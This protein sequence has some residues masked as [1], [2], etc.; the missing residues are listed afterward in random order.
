MRY[1]ILLVLTLCYAT[2]FGQ[3][4]AD[5]LIRDGNY[6]AVLEWIDGQPTTMTVE[7]KQA[8]ARALI[9][10]GRFG[11]A[12]TLINGLFKDASS[13][14]LAYPDLLNLRGFLN[15][16]T[17]RNDAAHEDFMAALK[18]Y[19][20]AHFSVHP[21]VASCHSNLGTLYVNTGKYQQAEDQFLQSLNIR[22][23]LFGTSHPEVAAA[24]NDLGL[25]Y[26]Q[27]DPGK[28][29][30]YYGKARD[31]Y[32]SNY[33][34]DHPKIAITSTNLGI[35]HKGQEDFS[36]AIQNFNEALRIWQRVFPDGHPNQA[37]VLSYL[38]QTYFSLG[39][40]AT[41]HTLFRDA[42]K[43]YRSAYGDRHPDLAATYNQ[44]ATLYIKERS[45]DSALVILQQALIANTKS[46]TSQ[47]LNVN[48]S[49]QDH[50]NPY[51]MVY[52]HQLKAQV[53]ETRY[54]AHTLRLE[55]LRRAVH[56]IA[57]CDT[58]I[59]SIRR[60]SPE[61]T[62]KIRLGSIV[63]EVF[64]DGVR[65]CHAIGELSVHPRSWEERAF[66][67][68]EKSKAAV[69]L[70]SIAEA[71][72]R[73]YAGLPD[74]LLESERNLK[75]RLQ[76]A[77]RRLAE[78][79]GQEEESVVRSELFRLKQEQAQFTEYLSIKYPRYFNLKYQESV[80]DVS[81]L[82]NLIGPEDAVVSYFVAEKNPVL[83]IFTLTKKKF[84]VD[85]RAIRGDLNRLINGFYNSIKLGNH[86]TYT[87]SA[88]AL[89]ALLKP[90]LPARVKDVVVIPSGALSKI[91]LEALPLRK[92]DRSQAFASR[93]W[94][95]RWTIG[96]DFSTALMVGGSES[97]TETNRRILLCAPVQFSPTR[98]LSDLPGTQME[99]DSIAR[100]FPGAQTMLTGAS[101]S[102]EAFRNFDLKQYRYIHL[103]THGLADEAAPELSRIFL[104]ESENADGDLFTGEIYNLNLKAD[105]VTLSA[106]QTGLG[107]VHRGEGMMGLSRALMYAGAEKVVVSYWS[108]SDEATAQLMVN[109]YRNFANTNTMGSSS[110]SAALAEAKRS[111][112]TDEKFKDPFYWAAFVMLG[113]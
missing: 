23:R 50:F 59:N 15:M 99:V 18:G 53:L 31:W 88:P 9:G 22:I 47:E 84:T 97:E 79:A 92:R 110:Y 30:T 17:G 67:Y 27:T 96:Y 93:Y 87:K 39:N 55:D 14:T 16:N 41:A 4:V 85:V 69:L 105:L 54:Y 35:L 60:Q 11:E 1:H 29:L 21:S 89:S 66:R 94:I 80:P 108:V 83:Y 20:A 77:A 112:I 111:M 19:T 28:A 71:S 6:A 102:E 3:S 101:A 90:D 64:E 61:E 40:T 7:L 32:A 8:R 74:S 45:Y 82:Q 24:L 86:T 95:N 104:R 33:G 65:L 44:L 81:E 58:L 51:V 46:F 91:P 75:A 38:A 10:L 43:Q 26:A 34:K 109:F 12:G 13:G 73:S 36:M 72:A 106:C 2:V 63:H 107:K 42:L 52:T 98:R 78:V 37:L 62:D 56:S 103:A 70:E 25:V 76:V 100:L 68:A 48:P 113:Y 5:S 57:I 49:S